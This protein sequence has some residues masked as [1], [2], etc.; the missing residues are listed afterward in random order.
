VQA[1][2]TEYS[3]LS[4]VAVSIVS[5]PRFSRAVVSSPFGT[6]AQP[7]EIFLAVHSSRM[8]K[9][10]WDQLHRPTSPGADSSGHDASEAA[11]KSGSRSVASRFILGLVRVA[12]SAHAGSECDGACA[13]CIFFGLWQRSSSCAGTDSTPYFWPSGRS[14]LPWPFALA[15][16]RVGDP[17]WVRRTH[18]G[19]MSILMHKER[20]RQHI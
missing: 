8:V 16:R 1:V 17:G 2:A 12:S 4:R 10:T 7:R 9:G 15:F 3:R 18:R 14:L 5:A 6:R 11:G 19:C 20:S 13:A